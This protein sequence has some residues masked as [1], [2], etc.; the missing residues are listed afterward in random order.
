MLLIAFVASPAAAQNAKPS[1]CPPISVDTSGWHAQSSAQFG[2][3]FLAPPRYKRKL[4]ERHSTNAPIDWLDAEDYWPITAVLWTFTFATVRGSSLAVPRDAQE[5]WTCV[6]PWSG[7]NGTVERFRSGRM[8]T[9][10]STSA[11][12]YVVRGSWRLP[13]G[14]LL[15]FSAAGTDSGTVAEMCGVI[16]T[17]RFTR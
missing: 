2:T 1:V 15:T 8:T 12:P 3:R 5:Y 13:N 10:P 11:V 7:R 16:S 4:W 6:E 9:G 14:R 17:L